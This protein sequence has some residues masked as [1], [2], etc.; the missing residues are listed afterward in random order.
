VYIYHTHNVY[1]KQD[2]HTLQTR[3]TKETVS[4]CH[5][6]RWKNYLVTRIK[7]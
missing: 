3:V 1:F 5:L 7:K 6:Y 4:H 2:R